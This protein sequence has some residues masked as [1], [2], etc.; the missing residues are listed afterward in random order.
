MGAAVFS[1]SSVIA[2]GQAR[3]SRPPYSALIFVD[4][5][6]DAKGLSC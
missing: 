3:T 2:S 6:F 5:L 1:I 4:H